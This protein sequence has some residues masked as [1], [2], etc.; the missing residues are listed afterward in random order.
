MLAG[1]PPLTRAELV[2]SGQE[3]PSEQTVSQHLNLC[4]EILLFLQ[5]EMDRPGVNC[6]Y[7]TKSTDEGTPPTPQGLNLWVIWARG[8]AV[9]KD[10]A[11]SAGQGGELKS[12]QAG[13]QAPGV[14]K[15][16]W[17]SWSPA[18]Q[19]LASL[20]ATGRRPVLGAE[21]HALFSAISRK[22]AASPRDVSCLETQGPR[23]PIVL[24]PHPAPP[25]PQGQLGACLPLSTRPSAGLPGSFLRPKNRCFWPW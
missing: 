22:H 9:L 19:V 18:W 15:P 5:H 25:Q 8:Q 11:L 7:E 16:G 23:L 14:Q 24:S 4:L 12:Q 1:Q 6:G 10:G 2:S 20:F 17:L 21:A 3:Q 13:R